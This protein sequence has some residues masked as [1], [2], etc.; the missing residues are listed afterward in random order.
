MLPLYIEKE[1]MARVIACPDCLERMEYEYE[2]GQ[3][4]FWICRKCGRMWLNT[5]IKKNHLSQSQ[6]EATLRIRD[7]QVELGMK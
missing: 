1:I 7:P 5:H 6:Y 4:Y 3:G 2:R